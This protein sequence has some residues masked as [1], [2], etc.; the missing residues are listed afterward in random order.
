MGVI[1]QP[2]YTQQFDK[3]GMPSVSPR[4]NSLFAEFLSRYEEWQSF[5]KRE[6][7]WLTLV[8]LFG[9]VSL[10]CMTYSFYSRSASLINL[11]LFIIA[12]R[13]YLKIRQSTNHLYVNVHILHHHL[14]GKLDVGFCDHRSPCQCADQ[15][16]KYVWETYRISLYGDMLKDRE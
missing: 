5:H 7:W 15:F 14:L 10:A 12:L 13:N 9:S 8:M 11:G 6:L 3:K 16:K 1:I 2:L 4:I